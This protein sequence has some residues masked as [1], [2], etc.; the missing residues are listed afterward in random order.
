MRRA[1]FGIV[2]SSVVLFAAAAHAEPV[3]VRFTEG[4]ARGFP[5]LRSASGEVLAQGDLVQ[6]ARANRVENRL[7]FRFHDGSIY[8]ETVTYDQGG[9]FT[10]L[11]YRVVQRGPSFPETLEASFERETGEYRVRY[12]ADE[13]SAEEVLSGSFEIPADAYNGLL[14]TVLKNLEAGQSQTVH[15]VAFTPKPRAIKMLLSRWRRSR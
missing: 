10:L 13:Q 7:V 2:A 6:V 11:S 3:T 5:V 4:V 1:L 9:V 12:R 14:C 15:I 8:D